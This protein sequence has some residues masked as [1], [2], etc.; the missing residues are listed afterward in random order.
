MRNIF[1]IAYLL[2]YLYAC[3]PKED[4]KPY[5][6]KIT[7]VND[8]TGKPKVHAVYDEQGR[9]VG[10]R[11]DI[12]NGAAPEHFVYNGNL[13]V[14]RS[15]ANL[16][17]RYSYNN[18]QL[19][20]SAFFYKNGVLQQRITYTYDAL[21]QLHSQ[22]RYISEGSVFYF[23]DST[24]YTV[25]ERGRPLELLH[26]RISHIYGNGTYGYVEEKYIYAYD[27]HMNRV[28]EYKVDNNVKVLMKE[29][30][31]DWNA[32]QS[33]ILDFLSI[34]GGISNGFYDSNIFY[35]P[36]NKD[37]DTHLA[38]SIK[39]Y[40]QGLLYQTVSISG[41]TI[42]KNNYVKSY[43]LHKSPVITPLEKNTVHYNYSYDCE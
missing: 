21:G 38:T 16:R 36:G 4:A 41:V 27:Q 15:V 25:Y 37:K 19:C 22:I 2:L 42:T 31:F 3:K 32:N 10:G 14:E 8:T 18:R 34:S 43:Q 5:D 29:S 9:Y 1:T 11:S 12:S 40:E 35:K 13:L 33:K 30:V 7:S 17:I 23:S 26:T 24:V 28:K 6:C 20:D 39:T